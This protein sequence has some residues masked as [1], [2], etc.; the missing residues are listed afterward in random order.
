MVF[1]GCLPPWFHLSHTYNKSHNHLSFCRKPIKYQNITE[2][3]N[4][5]ETLGKFANDM[6]VMEKVDLE[7]GAGC[8][9]PCTQALYNVKIRSNENVDF[10]KSW[11]SIAFSP[12]IQG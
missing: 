7:N 4:A 2:L 6:K 12:K 1:L 9:K 10:D 11:I 8:G 3:E 5:K